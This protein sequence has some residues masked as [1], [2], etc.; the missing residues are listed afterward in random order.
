MHEDG[1]VSEFSATYD[2]L[3]P[4]WDEWAAAVTPP[5]REEALRRLPEFVVDGAR[6]VELGCGTGVPVGELL[7]ARY[8]YT[9]VD[10]SPGMLER[11]RRAV[12]RGTFVH[13]DMET[14]TFDAASLGAV[15]AFFS[16]IHVP[17]EG[18]AALFASIANWLRPGGIFVGTLHSNDDPDD[19]SPDWL[20][21]GP[22]RWT[23]YDAATNR[24]LLE[25]AGFDVLDT[26]VLEQVEPDGCVIHPLLVF[27]R[28]P[29]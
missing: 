3:A 5:C 17:R 25:R 7:A 29:A 6:V 13:A 8:D 9:G 28:M 21:A 15:V 26:T 16:I 19:F 4:R 11:A 1:G 23:G 18:H 12:P 20:G 22:M 27:A 10:A 2:A 14:M 24:A